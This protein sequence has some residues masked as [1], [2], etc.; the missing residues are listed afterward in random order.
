MPAPLFYDFMPC[1]KCLK[2]FLW[3]GLICKKSKKFS[4]IT[5]AFPDFL[6]NTDNIFPKK[7]VLTEKSRITEPL[8]E[9]VDG[10]NRQVKQCEVLSRTAELKFQ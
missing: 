5:C 10:E 9:P 3:C 4:K 1:P 7:K 6:Y 8:R 2:I